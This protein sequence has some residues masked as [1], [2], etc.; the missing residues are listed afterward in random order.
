MQSQTKYVL[1]I[2]ISMVCRYRGQTVIG[3]KV[4][5]REHCFTIL[6][7]FF[8]MD[9]CQRINIIIYKLEGENNIIEKKQSGS[10]KTLCVFIAG[11]IQIF[12][13]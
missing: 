5:R 11:S 12:C 13:S 6:S 9:S 10:Q 2:Q 7:N 1:I 4:L 8:S 3:V